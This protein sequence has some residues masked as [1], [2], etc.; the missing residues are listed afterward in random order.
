[1]DIRQRNSLYLD[2]LEEKEK[3]RI[4][5]IIDVA[6]AVRM[7]TSSIQSK[8]SNKLYEKWHRRLERKITGVENRQQSNIWDSVRSKQL[9]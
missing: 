2:I 6:D 4:R 1:M 9:N 5:Y 3:D 8:K 7:G